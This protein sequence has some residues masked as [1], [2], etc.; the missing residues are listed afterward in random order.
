MP[1][2]GNLSGYGRDRYVD[3]SREAKPK[4]RKRNAV[5]K[6]GKEKKA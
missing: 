3:M 5:R 2:K 1:R 4:R 6:Q